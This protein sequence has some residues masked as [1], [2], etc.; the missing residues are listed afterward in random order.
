V[1]RELLHAAEAVL[2][3]EGMTGLTVRAVAAE[4]GVAPM[5]VYNRL[6]G[7]AGLVTA[8]LIGGFDRLQA[9]IEVGGEPEAYTRLRACCLRYREFALANPRLYA[10]LFEEAV[11][12]ERGSAEVKEHAA[13]CLG[14]L[15]RNLELAAMAGVL[16]APDTQ[17]AAQHIW[18][19]LHGAV[20]LEM[21]HLVQTPDPAATYRAFVDTVLRGLASLPARLAT[22]EKVPNWTRA[23]IEARLCPRPSGVHDGKR[24]CC[25]ENEPGMGAGFFRG[26]VRECPAEPG[27]PAARNPGS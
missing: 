17:E 20:A 24:A 12:R 13:A 27:Q 1:A 19:A 5:G 4:A 11:S 7:K 8:L 9:A 2:A 15:V 16:A 23:T 14:V 25:A 26:S 18:S 21:K 22:T 10:I 3:R 6:G